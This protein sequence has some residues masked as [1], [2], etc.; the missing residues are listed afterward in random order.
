M[1]SMLKTWSISRLCSF[2][3]QKIPESKN[4]GEELL[5]KRHNNR[6]SKHGIF[7]GG[8]GE[9]SCT[10]SN[11]E[12]NFPRYSLRTAGKEWFQ[13]T[14]QSAWDLETCTNK[15]CYCVSKAHHNI[16]IKQEGFLLKQKTG[17][18]L[19]PLTLPCNE[20]ASPTL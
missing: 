20:M 15:C 8:R 2:Y 1:H 19:K 9:F 13:S 18:L 4:L 12:L 17:S 5:L 11:R 16:S 7:K 6:D 14:H 3:F 10:A